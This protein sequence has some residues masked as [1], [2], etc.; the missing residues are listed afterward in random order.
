ME[1][2]IDNENP[3]SVVALYDLEG[4][5]GTSAALA[6]ARLLDASEICDK[7]GILLVGR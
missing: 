4:E 5:S 1:R 6:S 3:G 7:H 2:I